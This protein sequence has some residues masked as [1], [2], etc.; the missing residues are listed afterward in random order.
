[1]ETKYSFAQF[2]GRIAFGNSHSCIAAIIVLTEKRQ[3]IL[4]NFPI[5][6]CTDVYGQE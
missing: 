1:M 4:R 2:F 6:H 3:E 5:L